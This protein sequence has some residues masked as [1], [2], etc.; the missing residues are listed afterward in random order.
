[1]L[2]EKKDPKN[3]ASAIND[4]VRNYGVANPKG[5]LFDR[6]YNHRDH[7]KNIQVSQN[8]IGQAKDDLVYPNGLAPDGY[9]SY[10]SYAVGIN[11]ANVDINQIVETI[12]QNQINLF[13][14]QNRERYMRYHKVANRAEVSEG[15]DQMC[16]EALYAD[17]LGNICSLEFS[18]DAVIGES[19]KA[20]LTKIFRKKV[21]V[22]IFNIKK[23]GWSLIRSLLIEGRLFL[24]VVYSQEDDSIIGIRLLPS[25]N[26]IVLMQD[27][28]IIGYRQMVE[29]T[30]SSNLN[31]GG[32]NYIDFSPTQ[33]LYCDLD[34][35]GP[36]GINDIRSP[37][38]QAIK[39]YNQLNSIEDAVVAYR[40]L[41]GSEKLVFKIDTGRMPKPKAE[42]HMKDQMKQLS[43]RVDYNT[44]TGEIA[45][46]SRV[47]GLSEHY[48]LP[49]TS[50]AN[51]SSIERLQGGENLSNIDDLKYM[52][53]QL[54][55]SI[56]V[57][58]GRITALQGDGENFGNGKLGEVTQAEVAFARM[59]QRYQAP[60]ADMLL[61]LFLMVIERDQNIS[62]EIKDIN[63][64][65]VKFNKSNAFQN[66][67]D[68]EIWNTNLDTA[69]KAFEMML[70]DENPSGIF[71][72]KFV[73]KNIMKMSDQDLSDN[74]KYLKEEQ[75][76][77]ASNGMS[78][79]V[80]G[81]EDL[82][83]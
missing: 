72:K 32:K 48:F 44:A 80:A 6:Y 23:D 51:Q 26:M 30:V 20:H 83:M 7:K 59:V 46:Y 55:N 69:G 24:E 78:N 17:T 38:E 2:I 19:T 9:S 74:E 33:I 73:L 3:L 64:F 54:V 21:L 50:D 39:P 14:N 68:A 82:T 1:M 36:G 61:K 13:W 79:S 53:R 57:P 5:E 11:S 40:I 37:L 43:R 42:K 71:S 34:L 27:G 77:M 76:L 10:N 15:L 45:N 31:T 70:S 22:D 67:M 16:D 8:A 65:S 47:I 49:V 35:Y 12:A 62:D 4:R 58:P 63:N 29:G 81:D 41:W 25:Q 56:K 75:K 18:P 28:I 52:K 66:Y 60:L